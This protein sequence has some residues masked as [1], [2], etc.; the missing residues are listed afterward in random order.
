MILY[1]YSFSIPSEKVRLY[2]ELK[3]LP[4]ENYNVDLVKNQHLKKDF[5]S[6]N[7]QGLVPVLFDKERYL[8]NSND[9]ICYLET[10]YP[11]PSLLPEEK[12]IEDF[13]ADFEQEQHLL[14][15]MRIVS[16]DWVLRTKKPPKFWLYMKA[17]EMDKH[18]LP[19]IRDFY[20]KL[21]NGFEP[22]DIEEANQKIALFLEQFNKRFE[23]IYLDGEKLSLRDILWAPIIHRL[24]Q[25]DH[26]YFHKLSDWNNI[27]KWWN[28]VYFHLESL[29]KAVN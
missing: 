3:Q 21:A 13:K 23:G 10:H 5:L 14:S 27:E 2:L 7:P 28:K 26:A 8:A 15:P 18:P 11:N 22:S 9:I 1:N 4:Y 16:F 25:I 20:R 17:H 19:E 6:K 29:N 12:K 24:K